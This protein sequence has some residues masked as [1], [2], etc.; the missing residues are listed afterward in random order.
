MPA[1][2]QLRNLSRASAARTSPSTRA[3]ISPSFLSQRTSAPSSCRCPETR[4]AD[5]MECRYTYTENSGCFLRPSSAEPPRQ[6]HLEVDVFELPSTE[7]HN[8]TAL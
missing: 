7:R 3:Q 1:Y 6:E 5:Q 4:C 2:R 8:H